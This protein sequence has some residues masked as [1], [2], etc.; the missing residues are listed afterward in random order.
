MKRFLAEREA[1]VELLEGTPWRFA[2]K[3]IEEI[4]RKL[5]EPSPE[6]M[7]QYQINIRRGMAAP[8][9]QNLMNSGLSV[10]VGMVATLL[11][12]TEDVSPEIKYQLEY[13]ADVKITIYSVNAKAIAV[14]FDG[15]QIPGNYKITWNFR[16]DNGRKVAA[17]DYV[18]EVKIGKDK[19]VRKRIVKP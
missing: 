18:G 8:G 16:D 2:V 15:K 19:Y 3:N 14:I 4:P 6:E 1:R 9:V 5:L 12:I 13:P 17:G 10:P 11:G 7:V